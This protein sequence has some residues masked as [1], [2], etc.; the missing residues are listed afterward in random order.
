MT[1]SLVLTH[2]Y[3]GRFAPKVKELLAEGI[4]VYQMHVY[5][6]NFTHCVKCPACFLPPAV[7]GEGLE[8]M[9]ACPGC[10][11]PIVFL[12]CDKA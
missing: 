2:S 11:I 10:G 9:G 6:G 8:S 12:H 7:D 1:F 3:D 5:G 4:K